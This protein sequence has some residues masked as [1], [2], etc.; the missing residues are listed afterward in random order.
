MSSNKV[1]ISQLVVST[2]FLVIFAVILVWIPYFA[3][4]QATLKKPLPER[5]AIIQKAIE[6]TKTEKI[7]NKNEI[8]NI[9]KLQIESEQANDDAL[10]SVINVYKPFSKVL[11][12][13]LVFHL[14]SVFLIIRRMGVKKT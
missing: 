14:I 2:I 6:R 10:K 12:W 1:L 13:L 5:V 3:E 4:E 7:T 11:V 9:F 8:I